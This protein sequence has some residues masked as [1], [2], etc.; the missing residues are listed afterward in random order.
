LGY[1]LPWIPGMGLT[2]SAQNLLTFADTDGSIVTRR[3]QEFVGAPAL[4]RLVIARL[5]YQFGK[6]E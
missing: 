3:H 6:G 2:L 1:Q 5:T 4:G